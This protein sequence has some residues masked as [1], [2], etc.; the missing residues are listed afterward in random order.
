MLET[1][2]LPTFEVIA[3]IYTC[4]LNVSAIAVVQSVLHTAAL[5]II[6]GLLL[7]LVNKIDLDSLDAPYHR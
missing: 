6:D 4:S 1:L 5:C 2:V 3:H 7:L